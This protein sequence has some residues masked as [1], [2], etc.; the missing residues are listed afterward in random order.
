M[1]T[2]DY[3]LCVAQCL[4]GLSVVRKSVPPSVLLSLALLPFT[5]S[6]LAGLGQFLLDQVNY[7]LC[8]PV[9]IAYCR[10][11]ET[12]GGRHNMVSL[13]PSLDSPD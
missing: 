10:L 6:T 1:C 12:E 5:L 3:R 13:Y 4:D 2:R 9:A 7:L 8:H 11:A